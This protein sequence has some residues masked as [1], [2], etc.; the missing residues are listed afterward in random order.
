MVTGASEGIG[1]ETVLALAR[2]DC[3]V[4]FCA[5]RAERLELVAAEAA[6]A[7]NSVVPIAADLSRLEDV[8]RFVAEAT[9]KLG[10]VDI[11]V[12][13]AGT[14]AFATLFELPDERWL[15]DI[16]LKLLGYVRAARAVVPHMRATGG[17]II[18]V[19]GNAGKQ[20]LPYHL[21]GGA[22]NAGVLNFTLALAQQV[23]EYGIHVIAV[24]PGPVRTAR[25]E[26]QIGELAREW[27]V[28]PDEAERRFIAAL[29]L[30]RVPGP[31]EIADVIAFLASERAG[32]MTG[33]TVT[34][35]GGITRG[36]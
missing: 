22:A 9:E 18:N 32:Y 27:K 16:E 6:S 11:L 21:P 5:R 1:K 25:F 4:A 28:T 24:A 30:K 3:A 12:N 31:E 36:I 8:E 26:K 29:P 20:P 7:G 34:V 33:T 2:E 19:A 13:N 35:D 17:R 23:A 14:S 15:E 10:G